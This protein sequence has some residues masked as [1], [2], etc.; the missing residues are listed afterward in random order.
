V[1]IGEPAKSQANSLD[2]STSSHQSWT[3]NPLHETERRDIWKI[4]EDRYQT[5]SM[6]LSSQP[7]RLAPMPAGCTVQILTN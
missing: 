5:R 7:H 4:C 2:R 3:M 6:I 1:N